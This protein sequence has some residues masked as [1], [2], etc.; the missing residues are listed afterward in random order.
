MI[1]AT[2]ARQKTLR[3]RASAWRGVT[4]RPAIRPP[5]TAIAIDRLSTIATVNPIAAIR[6]SSA[7]IQPPPLVERSAHLLVRPAEA[8][9]LDRP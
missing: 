4:G 8:D 9:H 1:A 7:S 6:P 3:D 2:M 5:S